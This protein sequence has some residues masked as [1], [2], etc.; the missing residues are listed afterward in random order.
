MVVDLD[1]V[2]NSIVVEDILPTKDHHTLAI[3]LVL[4]L[5]ELDNSTLVEVGILIV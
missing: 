3:E 2:D 5:E 1:Q 4:A